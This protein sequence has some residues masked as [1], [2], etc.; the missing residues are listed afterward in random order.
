MKNIYKLIALSLIIS[1]C[2]GNKEQS[3]EDL[4]A[5]GDA[6]VI[7]SKKEELVTKQQEIANQIKQ[8]DEK[9]EDINPDRNVPLI[10]TITS[11]AETFQ[12]YLELQGGVETKQNL[13][14]TPEMGGILQRVYVK[15][16]QKVSRGQLLATVDDGGMGQQKAQLQIQ[17]DLAKTTFERQKRLWDQKIGSEI[18]YLQ[19]KSQ[20]EALQKGINQIDQQ[21]AKANVRAPF[22]GVIDDVI[23]E[24]GSVVAPGQTPLMRIVNLSDMYIET[25]VPERYITDITEG[26][27]VMV[28]FPVLGKTL[29]AKVRQTG[30]FIN[31]ANRTFKIEIAVPNKDK[32]I[33]PNLTA[34]LKINDYTNEEAI[35][36]PQSVISENANGEQYI[37]I[38]KD[39][40]EDKAV[41]EQIIIETG[42]TQGDNIEIIS[43]LKPDMEIIKEGARS[44]KDEQ[45]VKITNKTI[46]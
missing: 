26:K 27:D 33:K 23:T 13:V 41:A 8:L 29:N 42:K 9:L 34:R 35:L 39:K 31:P 44:V 17:A 24:Q 22:S 5:T 14:I 2:S 28:E 20:Y 16:G 43:G 15:E 38:L 10:T 19:A 7:Q 36:I 6:K 18:Q 4:I 30:N 32:S 1:S 40:K 46:D 3:I 37:Y 11:K 21:L 12:H 25:D 45:T